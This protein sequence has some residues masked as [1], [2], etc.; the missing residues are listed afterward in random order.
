MKKLKKLLATISAIVVCAVSI[1]PLMLNAIALP[2]AGEVNPYTIS[3]TNHYGD[4][5]VLWQEATDY[6]KFNEKDMERYSYYLENK[7]VTCYDGGINVYITEKPYDNGNY[8][9]YGCCYYYYRN[10]D[11]TT[12]ARTSTLLLYFDKFVLANENDRETLKNYLTDNNIPYKVSGNEITLQFDKESNVYDKLNV[13]A[14]IKENTGF[15][16]D[17]ISPDLAVFVSDVE[18]ALPEKTLNGDAN[19][20]GIVDIADAAAII[21]HIGNRGKYGL[22]IQGEANADCYNTGDGVTGMDA[23]A[24]QKLEAGLIE[25]LD[26]A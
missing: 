10:E 14:D 22:S 15:V 18:Y 6:W 11:G 8:S 2:F 13:Y 9:T 23:I 7:K 16:C 5:C 20:D 1:S 3:F 21:Q 17:W 19:E 4:K 26:E 25:S 12:F 24:I